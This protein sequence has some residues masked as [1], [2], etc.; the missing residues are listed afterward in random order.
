MAPRINANVPDVEAKRC[1]NTSAH[2]LS[3]SLIRLPRNQWI[4]H[5]RRRGTTDVGSGEHWTQTGGSG[6]SEL[7]VARQNRQA[8]DS[9]AANTHFFEEVAMLTEP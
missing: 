4:T 2:R 9:D 1:L 6:R 8:A 5:S 7:S 3:R